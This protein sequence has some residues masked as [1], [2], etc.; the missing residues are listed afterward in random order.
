[1]SIKGY[2]KFECQIQFDD[3][4]EFIHFILIAVYVR[5][6]GTSVNEVAVPTQFYSHL[7]LGT[8]WCLLDK[9]RSRVKLDLHL[10]EVQSDI[11]LT[12]TKPVSSFLP[13][14]YE[15]GIL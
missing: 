1:M 11:Y 9:T 7:Q 6:M 13:V 12:A 15:D 2:L 10:N 4:G 5:L 3:F 14:L 8:L